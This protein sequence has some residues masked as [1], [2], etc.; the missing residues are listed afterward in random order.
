VVATTAPTA[1]PFVGY[2]GIKY[3][4]A[5]YVGA[6][7]VWNSTTAY[8]AGS[9]VSNGVLGVA[10]A[11]VIIWICQVAV[12]AGDPAPTAQT[13]D[14]WTTLGLVWNNGTTPSVVDTVY[15]SADGLRVFKA[16]TVSTNAPPAT[17]VS[18]TDW[19]YLYSVNA[20][21]SNYWLPIDDGEPYWDSGNTYYP[22]DVVSAYVE[23]SGDEALPLYL[24]L[25][26]NS[27]SAPPVSPSDWKPLTTLNCSIGSG[28]TINNAG[29]VS[30]AL[31]A[32]AGISLVPSLST[33]SIT[34]SAPSPV[35][36]GVVTITQATA[37]GSSTPITVAG[38]TTA[39]GKVLITVAQNGSNVLP[40]VENSF[41]TGTIVFQTPCV[42]FVRVNTGTF[43]IV[44]DKSTVAP[45]GG[46]QTI[47]PYT[48]DVHYTVL[49]L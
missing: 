23:D 20:V 46:T 47:Q 41:S 17:A 14:D 38:L 16:R 25:T 21:A 43:D 5:P 18:N 1:N 24:S 7:T 3:P 39:T 10:P 34:I 30:T 28:I 44:F 32:G 12:P 2:G 11:N 26:K 40:Y 29:F 4:V 31:V 15:F 33:E 9:I 45:T 48:V 13:G 22:G 37:G 36:S 35:S 27:G 19:L 8:P 42:P 49:S 6:S